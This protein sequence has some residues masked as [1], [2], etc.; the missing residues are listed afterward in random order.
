M[1]LHWFVTDVAL[2][3]PEKAIKVTTNIPIPI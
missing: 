3:N 1:V 2:A